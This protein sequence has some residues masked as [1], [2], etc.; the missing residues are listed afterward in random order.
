[1]TGVTACTMLVTAVGCKGRRK[2]VPP[3][4]KITKVTVD[5]AR[6]LEPSEVAVHMNL[7]PSKVLGDPNYYVPRLE[8]LDEDRIEEFY[9]AHGHFEAEVESI[10][11]EIRHPERKV[12]RQR[13]RV[14]VVLDEGPPTRIDAIEW[15][16]GEAIEHGVALD[17]K[18][19]EKQAGVSHGDTFSIPKFERSEPQILNALH[20]QGYAF[21]KLERKAEI[22]RGR[23]TARIF[24]D[25][26]PG[27]RFVVD[28]LEIEGLERIRE[29]FVRREVEPA[30]GRQYS[31]TLMHQT[32][33]SVYGLGVFGTVA[34]T[35]DRPTGPGKLA[36]KVRVRERD[37]QQL[38]VG[39]LLE[40]DPL[41]WSQRAGVRYSHANLFRNVTKFEATMLV[42][43]AELP[44][45]FSIQAHGPRALLELRLSKRGL[46]ERKLLWEEEPSIGVEIREGYQYWFLEN[47][48]GVSRFLGKIASLGLTYNNRYVDYYNVTGGLLVQL[49]NAGYPTPDPYVDSYLELKPEVFWLD[50]LMFPT[51]G[52]HFL[53][54]YQFAN[55]YLGSDFNYHLIE[56]ELRGYYR[57]HDRI[58]LA[59]RARVGFVFPYWGSA[60]AP[61][62]RSFYLGGV[63]DVRGWP[64][65]RLS[66]RIDLCDDNGENCDS[67]PIGGNTEILGNLE[68]RVRVWKELWIAAFGDMGDIQSGVA[69]IHPSQWFYS[70]GGGLRYATPLGPVRVD[71]GVVLNPQDRYYEKRRWALHLT[72]GEAF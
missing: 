10:D 21:A 24:Y 9:G 5:G 16:W 62:D 64:L 66:P 6:A 17:R 11:V 38:D 26:R 69:E 29:K 39:A 71:V 34:V 47:R 67:I 45:P 54:T 51:N 3:G 15:Q 46:L 18:A 41:M 27:E 57:P 63:S 20:E 22:D 53:V 33:A 55:R 42:G 44:H 36:V 7:R 37:M 50:N 32:E 59:A 56:P 23:R 60:S 40:V 2:S 49:A 72:L 48:A 30:I 58:Q 43:W 13:A 14:H 70:T 1:M 68:L 8:V 65:R 12:K 4:P 61:F 25:V 31:P 52:V 19:V 35:P 28:V